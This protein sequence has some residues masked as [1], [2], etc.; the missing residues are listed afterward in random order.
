[1]IEETVRRWHAFLAGRSEEG[2]DA[3]LADDVVFHSP[4]VFTPQRG[5]ALAKLYL[6]AA[7]A[8]F[9]GDPASG[10]PAVSPER[11]RYTK[12]VVSGNHAVLEFEADVD[13]TWVNGVDILTCNDAGQISEFRVMLR[14]LRAVNL[15]HARMKAML[16]QLGGAR[17]GS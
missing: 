12:E 9:G 14:P 11:F 7:G 13:G 5:K 15:M 10:G 1:M 2:L 17:A 16:E 4:I 8:T 3:L 6:T